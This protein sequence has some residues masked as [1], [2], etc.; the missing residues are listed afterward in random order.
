MN[1]LKIGTST[2]VIKTLFEKHYF[3]DFSLTKKEN[4]N[5]ITVDLNK[6]KYLY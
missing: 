6:I 3:I 1:I 4:N 2:I 5:T